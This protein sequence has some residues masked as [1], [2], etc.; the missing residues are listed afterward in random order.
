MTLTDGK[1]RTPGLT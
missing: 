1:V